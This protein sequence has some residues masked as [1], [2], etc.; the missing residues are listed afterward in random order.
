MD[1]QPVLVLPRDRSIC[2]VAGTQPCSGTSSAICHIS[3]RLSGL[4]AL[5]SKARGTVTRSSGDLRRVGLRSGTG[6]VGH[7]PSP[8]LYIQQP[9]FPGRSFK[10]E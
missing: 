6:T 5:M 1:S 10:N 2:H 4:E 3:V 7:S 8:S 9:S